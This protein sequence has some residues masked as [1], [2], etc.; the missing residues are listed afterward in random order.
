MYSRRAVYQEELVPI[1]TLFYLYGSIVRGDMVFHMV[2]IE[3]AYT[4]ADSLPFKGLEKTQ[5]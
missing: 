1:D 3:K 4:K 2:C 5:E